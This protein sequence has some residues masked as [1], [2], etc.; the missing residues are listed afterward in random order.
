MADVSNELD[1]VKSIV[2]LKTYIVS[3]VSRI[4]E[5]ER[6][7]LT[8]EQPI[9]LTSVVENVPEVDLTPIY[10]KLDELYKYKPILDKLNN[11]PL[12]VKKLIG[13]SE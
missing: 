2:G 6:N 8:S 3:L 7:Q 9:E 4:E 12:W 1:S 13:I 10:S 5:L 11:L